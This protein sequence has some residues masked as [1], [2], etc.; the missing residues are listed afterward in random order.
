MEDLK[1]EKSHFTSVKTRKTEPNI[2]QIRKTKNPNTPSV[3]YVWNKL[4]S[5][6][7]NLATT[8]FLLVA[9]WIPNEK[10]NLEPWFL[11]F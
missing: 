11:S 2:G 1:T 7:D 8:I 3:N 10:V 4:A 9:S 6:I 5:K